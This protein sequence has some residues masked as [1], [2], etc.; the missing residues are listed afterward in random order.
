MRAKRTNCG[1]TLALA[2]AIVGSLC[3]APARADPPPTPR[4]QV[5]PFWPKPLPHNWVTGEI[6]GTC[7]DSQD[8]VFVVTRGFQKG[9]LVSPEGVGGRPEKSTASPPVIA[10]DPSNGDVYIADGYGNHRVVVF[11]KGGTYLRQ[12]GGVGTGLGQF[13]AGDGGH[14]HCVVIG[15]DGLVYACD[16]GQDRMNVYR[17]DG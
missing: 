17:K 3:S 15:K 8:H 6:G 9:G 4:F 16:R 14:P 7:V 13:T 12:M 5:D 1:T 2:V 11:D 10:V